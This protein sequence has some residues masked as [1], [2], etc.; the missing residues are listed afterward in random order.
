MF[1]AWLHFTLLY[2]LTGTAIRLVTMKFPDNPVS[3]ALI[4]A[5]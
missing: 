3:R 2:L 5:H 1:I 4:F